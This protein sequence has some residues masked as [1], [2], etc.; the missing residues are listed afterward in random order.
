VPPLSEV[1]ARLHE[2]QEG[3]WG[4]LL[5]QL[6]PRL[7]GFFE[8]DGVDHHLAEDIAQEVLETIFRKLSELRDPRRFDSWVRMIARNRMRSRLR[9]VRFTEVLEDEER[10]AAKDGFGRLYDDDLRRLVCE[11][12]RRFGATAR[13]MLELKI[14]EDRSPSEIVA[15]MGISPECFRKRFH[16]AIKTLR[17][18]VK[19]RIDGAWRRAPAPGRSHSH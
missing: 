15:I 10:I 19:S 16:V 1:I 18:R 3:S 9:R 6:L 4:E 17:E 11:E 13:R 5:G 14:L 8:R 2:G 7:V 12:V